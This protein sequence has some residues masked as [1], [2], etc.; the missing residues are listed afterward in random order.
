M[1][2]TTKVTNNE[3]ERKREASGEPRKF[4]PL[5]FLDQPVE[6]AG[7]LAESEKGGKLQIGS[8]SYSAEVNS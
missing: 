3:A 4:S 5:S 7:F 2:Q 6:L 8:T 1:N